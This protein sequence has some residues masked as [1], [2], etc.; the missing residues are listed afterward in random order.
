[1]RRTRS[2][3]PLTLYL[4]LPFRHGKRGDCIGLG[5]SP[6]TYRQLW[7]EGETGE[8]G[9]TV[10]P[11]W[12]PREDGAKEVAIAAN[13]GM[14]IVRSPPL[15]VERGRQVGFGI[16]KNPGTPLRAGRITARHGWLRPLKSWRNHIKTPDMH[17]AWRTPPGMQSSPRQMSRILEA[18]QARPDTARA[19]GHT[20]PLR[21]H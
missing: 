9:E 1:M 5:H 19:K 6:Q 7:K 3:R 11:R 13:G 8:T 14:C 4:L 18:T 21:N 2:G 10:L 17:G 20:V 15:S 12:R 16:G